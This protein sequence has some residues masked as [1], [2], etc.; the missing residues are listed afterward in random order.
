MNI[1]IKEHLNKIEKNI[2]LISAAFTLAISIIIIQL[3][4]G[5]IK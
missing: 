4:F 2:T 3:L 5:I 1:K